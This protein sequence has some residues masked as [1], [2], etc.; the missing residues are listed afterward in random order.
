MGL[1]AAKRPSQAT[2]STTLRN[3]IS[4]LV[5]VLAPYANPQLVQ[6]DSPMPLCEE[7]EVGPLESERRDFPSFCRENDE[8][9][10]RLEFTDLELDKQKEISEQV[11][12][13]FKQNDM[14]PKSFKALHRELMEDASF[15][16]LLEDFEGTLGKAHFNVPQNQRINSL[17]VQLLIVN[18][19]VLKLGE[20]R[21]LCRADAVHT[22]HGIDE[23][24]IVKIHG[25]DL[26]SEGWIASTD[27]L[28]YE[29]EGR[30][31]SM[32]SEDGQHL[33]F[34]F[35]D[36]IDPKK[37]LRATTTHELMHA[38]VSEEFPLVERVRQYGSKQYNLGP[39]MKGVL[40]VR[41]ATINE[42]HELIAV[43]YTAA[44]FPG[45]FGFTQ[46]RF[47]PELEGSF[48]GGGDDYALAAFVLPKLMKD[49]PDTGGFQE[50]SV[51]SA[52]QWFVNGAEQ[53]VD[54]GLAMICWAERSEAGKGEKIDCDTG[55]GRWH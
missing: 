17:L 19:Y 16:Q 35:L 9:T 5:I 54:F 2:L 33:Y 26:N 34:R 13:H 32:N 12:Q 36:N 41:R 28:T 39:E 7:G 21:F 6:F 18:D 44:L 10:L 22:F 14:S 23:N 50:G 51:S 11:V 30:G 29:G 1:A 37:S 53:A 49:R 25:F 43:S 8:N 47:D 46:S 45:D 42:L 40:A 24:N 27:E 52:D 20:E 48:V 4:S 15:V 55:G 38:W 3:A 31:V